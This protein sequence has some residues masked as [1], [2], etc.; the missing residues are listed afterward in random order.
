[1]TSSVVIIVVVAGDGHAVDDKAFRLY[2]V[3]SARVLTQT[4]I[5]LGLHRTGKDGV[6]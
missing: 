2:I 6:A 5:G 4:I 3:R 1:L